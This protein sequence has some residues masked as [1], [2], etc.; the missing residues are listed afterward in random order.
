MSFVQLFSN[1][2]AAEY[3]EDVQ[4]ATMP[5]METEKG[6]FFPYS[7]EVEEK[8]EKSLSDRHIRRVSTSSL[9]NHR[10]VVQT[11]ERPLSQGMFPPE[12]S[13]VCLEFVND[14]NDNLG[15]EKRLLQAYRLLAETRSLAGLE[16]SVRVDIPAARSNLLLLACLRYGRLKMDAL[17]SLIQ[18]IRREEV[19][20]AN[21]EG[22]WDLATDMTKI[23]D[24]NYVQAQA[25]PVQILICK[26]YGLVAELI[27]KHYAAHFL[28]GVTH[29]QK[30]LF[31]AP[32]SLLQSINTQNSVE[33][34]W[35]AKYA[36]EGFVRLRDNRKFLLDIGAAVLHFLESAGNLY[37]ADVTGGLDKLIETG[38]AIEFHLEHDWY[39][40]A[41]VLNILADQAIQNKEA[42]GG[43]LVYN[44]KYCESDWEFAYHA[45]S[46]LTW[47]CMNAATPELR[48]E[49]LRGFVIFSSVNAFHRHP[50]ST[51]ALNF[52]VEIKDH[53]V[54]VRDHLIGQLKDLS[55]HSQDLF[56]RLQAGLL[57]DRFQHPENGAA[58]R[59]LSTD[60]KGKKRLEEA[61]GIHDNKKLKMHQ[62][63]E[64][65][66]RAAKPIRKELIRSR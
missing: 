47:V 56:V 31:L 42:L 2:K 61:S 25:I 50:S 36:F 15:D 59:D 51:Q 34:H 18:L 48:R 23:M 63:A 37:R 26:V 52:H 24:V 49:A 29:A 62:Q 65:T 10:A 14:F 4:E 64:G 22:I 40:K 66:N 58:N 1:N 5:Q 17:N 7:F 28:N 21:A 20:V 53:N 13:T 32:I 30:N 60:P 27:H 12:Y 41:L 35:A 44:R 6:K 55:L 43:L 8:R 33:L 19:N 39:W 16:P 38:K 3:A 46:T 57:R 11:K 9:A 45:L 54:Y